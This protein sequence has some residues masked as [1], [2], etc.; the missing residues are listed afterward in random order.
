MDRFLLLD[1]DPG[2]NGRG[3][4]LFVAEELL[5]EA[6]VGQDKPRRPQRVAAVPLETSRRDRTGRGS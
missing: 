5:D 2:V 4:E 3:F 6:D 1:A